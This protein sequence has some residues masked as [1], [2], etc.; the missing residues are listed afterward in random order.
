VNYTVRSGGRFNNTKLR[1]DFTNLF[2]NSNINGIT[3]ANSSTP[4]PLST[5]SP[6]VNPFV[7]T[8]QTPISPSDNVAVNSGRSI[9]LTVTFGTSMKR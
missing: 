8:G 7:A 3:L 5:G 6:F 2:N 1:I 4:A 9:M